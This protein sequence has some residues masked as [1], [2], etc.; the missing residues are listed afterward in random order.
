MSSDGNNRQVVPTLFAWNDLLWSLLACLLVAVILVSQQKKAN[1]DPAAA[2]A[3]GNIAV[4][5]YWPDDTDVDID[6]HLSGPG[7]EHVY[8]KHPSGKVWNLLRDDMGAIN[9]GTPRNFENASTRGIPAGEYIINVSAYRGA[10]NLFPV[11]VGVELRINPSVDGGGPPQLVLN[12]KVTLDHIGEE[13]TAFRFTADSNGHVNPDSINA[14][15]VALA[16]PDQ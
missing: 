13:A 14:I 3:I 15:Y 5:V 4:F 12:R 10:D 2:R 1:S 6:T 7:G 8:Y 16:G 9:D 11:T